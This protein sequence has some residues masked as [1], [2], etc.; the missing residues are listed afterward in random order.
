MKNRKK[1]KDE[2]MQEL[3]D[4]R[5]QMEAL[6]ATWQAN[7]MH[8]ENQLRLAQA[9]IR[10]LLENNVTGIFFWKEEGVITEANDFFLK[11]IGR[12]RDEVRAGTITIE[13][14]TPAEYREQDK[15]ALWEIKQ[16]RTIIPFEKEFVGKNGKRLKAL[17][18]ASRV[19]A[20]NEFIG[21]IQVQGERR[22]SENNQEISSLLNKAV[23]LSNQNTDNGT[24]ETY[25]Y[26]LNGVQILLVD[27]EVR[28]RDRVYSV[29][30]NC[31]AKVMSVNTAKDALQVLDNSAPDLLLSDIRLPDED[32]YSFIKK[33]RT[34]SP[35]RGGNIPAAAFT[36]DP[37]SGSGDPWRALL[38]G[39]HMQIN[40][41]IDPSE[42]LSAVARLVGRGK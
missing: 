34:R 7:Q 17:F 26:Q 13:E 16:G 2:L 37:R 29:L 1:N 18:N 33:V 3:A 5:G 25:G 27:N 11:M 31:G 22:V 32:G 6:N 42:L 30:A 20:E 38:S 28:S 14:L 15:R 36:A 35:E 21:F 9:R 40:K 24:N 41:P 23:D 12:T 39:F 8:L 4:L 10:S 19:D